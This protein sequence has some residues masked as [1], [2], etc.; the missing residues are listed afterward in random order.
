MA[1]ATDKQC[2]LWNALN[3]KL[4]EDQRVDH[5]ELIKAANDKMRGIQLVSAMIDDLKQRLGQQ[6]AVAQTATV[7]TYTPA[8]DARVQ[9]PVNEQRYTGDTAKWYYSR[10]GAGRDELDNQ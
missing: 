10:N 2:K 4:P 7:T 5:Y 9:R 6:P 8:E 1:K 3:D